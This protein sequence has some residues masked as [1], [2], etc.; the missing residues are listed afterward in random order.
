MTS[1]QDF[2]N[3]WAS[4]AIQAGFTKLPNC[5][6]PSWL[7]AEE[8]AARLM[9]PLVGAHEDEVVLMGTLTANLHFMLASFYQRMESNN[10]R[11]T[12]IMI[13]DG[14]FASDRVS[15]Q[16]FEQNS[17]D[18]TCFQYAIESQVSL[19]GLD[20]CTEIVEIPFDQSTML[21]D[22]DTILGTIDAHAATTSI[23]LLSAIQFHTGQLLDIPRITAHAHE[24][25]IIVGWDL[26]H[27]V[28]NIQLELHDWNVDFAVWCSY[29]YLNAGP[30][31]TAGTFIHQRH[32]RPDKPRLAG[33]WGVASPQR[34]ALGKCTLCS[35]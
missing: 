20:P 15:V 29:K 14:A 8:E 10:N 9:A 7:E 26:A 22:L 16:S 19:H 4:Q 2:L 28:G 25:G 13:E 30:G 11:R 21:L 24:R 1:T 27:A 17:C 34:F 3:Q 35:S 18:L 23:L 33:W 5:T 31:A 12:K 6:V 32:A